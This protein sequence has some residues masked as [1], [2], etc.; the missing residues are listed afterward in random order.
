LSATLRGSPNNPRL[1]ILGFAW[2][3]LTEK[4]NMKLEKNLFVAAAVVLQLSGCA[5]F[6]G[7]QQTCKV[8][9]PDLAPGVYS[10]GC[11]DGLADGYGEVVGAGSYRGDFRA[12]RKHGKGIK[13]M[14]NG[15][16]YAGDFSDDYRHGKGVYVWGDKT[17]WAGD[18]YEGEYRR[19]LRQGW[20]VYQWGNGDRYEGWWQDDLRMWMSVMEVRRALAAKAGKAQVEKD[21]KQ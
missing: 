2:G 9:D 13:T 3:N 21:Q 5:L 4:L 11:E 1:L 17:S 15:D 10:G 12:G 7:A 20:G 8:V 6:G 19:D 14:P 18:S 16:R